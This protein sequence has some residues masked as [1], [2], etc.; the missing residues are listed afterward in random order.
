MFSIDTRRSSKKSLE[1]IVIT[2]NSHVLKFNGKATIKLEKV[3]KD[4]NEA[5]SNLFDCQNDYVESTMS[6]AQQ[7]KLFAL[8]EKAHKIVDSGKAVDYNAELELLKPIVD[9]IID[10]I[11]VYK[12]CDFIQYSDKYLRI[13]KDLSKA[14]SKGDYPEQTTIMDHD[15]TGMVKYAFSVRTIYPIVFG[16]I[17]RFEPIM[18][19]ASA[20]LVC[21]RLIKDNP[22]L[23]Q[24]QGWQKLSTYVKFAFNKRGIP[25]QVDSVTSVENFVDKVLYNA[26]FGRLCCAVIP[27]TEEGKNIATAINAAVKLHEAGSA[28]FRDK[29]RPSD[30]DDDKRSIL[31]KYQISEEVKSSN[32]AVQAEFFSFGLYDENDAPRGGDRFFYQAQALGIKRHKLIEKVYDN[33]PPNW[34]FELTDHIRKILQLVYAGQL[35]EETIVTSPFIYDA[36]HYTQLMAAIAVAQV[37]LSEMGYKYLPSLL[38]AIHDPNGQR[39]LADA[40]KLNTEEKDYL[41]SICEVQSRN[42]E[43]RSFNEA[44]VA[45]EQFLELFGNG[46][47]M[48][49]LEYGVLDNEEIYGRVK[50]GSL[51]PIDID[52]EVKKEF[53]SLV[54]HVN[55]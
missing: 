32:E 47:W 27:E 5:E 38:G 42:N 44:L 55:G 15:Y 31:D 18:G 9:E 20:E 17:A 28:T 16:L 11:N 53:M 54:R 50:E 10:F 33:L 37:W 23:S 7:E 30:D 24:M 34:D 45:A 48:S 39:A 2:M 3:I 49:N 41:A 43:G 6:H 25:S 26:V 12:Y 21:G 35:T 51:F 1:A 40:L 52:V 8:Y 36:A 22:V 4:R 14:A 46:Q 29:D 19:Q 13:P